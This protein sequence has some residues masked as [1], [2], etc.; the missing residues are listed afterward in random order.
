MWFD[1]Y[2]RASN[3]YTFDVI[4]IFS[5]YKIAEWI[6]NEVVPNHSQYGDLSNQL[7]LWNRYNALKEVCVK[8]WYDNK[9]Y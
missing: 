7:E 2:L 9:A 3:A 8:L 4:Q 1:E 5:S 6:V